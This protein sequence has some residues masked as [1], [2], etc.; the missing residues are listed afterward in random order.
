MNRIAQLRKEKGMSQVSLSLKLNI[1]QK[2]ISAYETAKSEPSISTYMQ[3]AN[4]FN[5]SV[6]YLIGYTNIRQPIDK[7]I[8]SSI[9]EDECIL[10]NNFRKLSAKHQNIAQGVIIGLQQQI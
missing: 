2:M 5:T 7:L 1:S 6:D 4:I 8:Q 9:S 3:L 10:L